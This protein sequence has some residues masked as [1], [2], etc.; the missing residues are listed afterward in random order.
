MINVQKVPYFHLLAENGG[1][2]WTFTHMLQGRPRA[3]VVFALVAL[4][5][6]SSGT[7]LHYSLGIQGQGVGPSRGP[8][9]V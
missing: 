5:F 7:S 6:W 4:S 2:V 9:D 1:R 8:V 3:M